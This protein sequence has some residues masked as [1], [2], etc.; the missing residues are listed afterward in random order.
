MPE[1]SVLLPVRNARPWLPAALASIAR[2][3]FPDFEIVAV[4]DGS[5]DGSGE[6]LERHAQ[7]ERRLRVIRTPANGLP[8]ALNTALGAA[9]GTLL[10][11]HDADDVSHRERFE[12]QLT[13]L[14]TRPE[15]AVAGTRVR[16]FPAAQAGAGMRRWA[17]WHNAL[18]EHDAMRREALIDSPLAH[19][20]AMLRHTALE[21]VGGWAEHGWA[22]DLDLW[23][24]LFEAGYR[25]VKLPR[26]LY[27]WRQH[28]E[29]ATRTD[30]RYDHERFL[31]LKC[32][33]LERG[34][35]AGARG[36]TLVGVGRSLARWHEALDARGFSIARLEAKRAA[37]VRPDALVPPIVLAFVAPASRL[38]WRAALAELGRVELRDFI[39]VA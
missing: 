7:T 6:W 35:L 31:A 24:R 11:R 33:A 1:L 26:A 2:Q 16:L 38:G 32:A 5:T 14:R 39:F 23:V 21:A 25:F 22:E 20:T 4:D 29:S 12:R 10:A 17:A 37:G 15:I 19:G 27:G 8:G 3:T 30:P 13:L 18:L 36:V 9:R 28:P 34:L